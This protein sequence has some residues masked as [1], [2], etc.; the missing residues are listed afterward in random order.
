MREAAVDAPSRFVLELTHI[1]SPEGASIHAII[2]GP[3]VTTTLTRTLRSGH[4]DS[5]FTTE[6]A[7]W[8]AAVE[9]FDQHGHD[10]AR[11]VAKGAPGWDTPGAG[12]PWRKHT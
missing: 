8:A 1:P 10:G 5:R 2:S 9:W 3:R 12:R 7:A 11:L 6:A 4:T